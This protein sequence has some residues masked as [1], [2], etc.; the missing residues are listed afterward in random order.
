MTL[1]S[2]TGVDTADYS[3][4]TGGVTV[5][6]L[7]TSAQ[8]TGGAGIDTLSGIENLTG[9]SSG[10]TLVG[11]GAANVLLGLDGADLLNGG[12]GAD[13][14][15]GGFGNDVYVVNKTGD[16]VIEDNNPGDVDTGEGARRL[17]ARRQRGEPDPDRGRC[18]RRHRQR[19]RQQIDRQ[20]QCAVGVWT[21]AIC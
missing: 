15:S 7:L 12:G 16:Q 20:R 11:N 8:D 9:S 4:A 19:T 2:S 5:K 3:D 14:M 21:A 6:L 13:Q 1:D 17:H 18:H 10:D